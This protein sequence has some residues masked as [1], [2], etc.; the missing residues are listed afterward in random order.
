MNGGLL[1]SFLVSVPLLAALQLRFWAFWDAATF[2]LL[3]GMFFT[4]FGCLLNGCCAGRPTSGAIALYLPDHR[5][6][7]CRRIPTELFEAGFAVAL[8]IGAAV[9]WGRMPFDGAVF[10][11]A[12]A[13]YGTG[14]PLLDLGRDR[15]DHRRR[16]K[17]LTVN[18]T[19]SVALV[20][21]SIAALLVLWIPLARGG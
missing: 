1:L 10:L 9:V 15:N 4:K 16:P 11:S 18:V 3:V 12:L 19:I 6:I 7:W 2:T 5:G 8:A 13:L 20:A 14:K 17:W 21:L